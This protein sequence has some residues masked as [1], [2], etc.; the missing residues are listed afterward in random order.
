L[1]A[2]AVTD[3]I[4]GFIIRY[5]VITL[6]D[7]DL[8][9]EDDIYR[10]PSSCTFAIFL[11]NTVEFRT[12]YLPIYFIVEPHERIA[13]R[14]QL[15]QMLI[16]RV[17]QSSSAYFENFFEPMTLCHAAIIS[18]G[19]CIALRESR[20]FI[21]VPIHYIVRVAAVS[22]L[23]RGLKILERPPP[24]EFSDAVRCDAQRFAGGCEHGIPLL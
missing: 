19:A 18:Y 2:Q 10:L 24:T 17:Q 12:E 6:K 13:K 11:I 1:E 14:S 7:H 4:F 9:H 22:A 20:Q 15:L 8:E 23:R 3:E 21:E 16:P 5:I